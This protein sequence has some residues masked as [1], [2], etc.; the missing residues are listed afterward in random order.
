[1]DLVGASHRHVVARTTTHQRHIHPGDVIRPAHHLHLVAPQPIGQQHEHRVAAPPH[2]PQAGRRLAG[3]LPQAAAC[4]IPPAG[5]HGDPVPP[6]GPQHQPAHAGVAG[7]QLA[8][9]GAADQQGG[10][11]ALADLGGQSLEGMAGGAKQKHQLWRTPLQHGRQG[12]LHRR[13]RIP[14]GGVPHGH[15]AGSVVAAGG[16]GIGGEVGHGPGPLQQSPPNIDE[17]VC[18]CVFKVSL[19]LTL[20]GGPARSGGPCT[21][22]A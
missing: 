2:L 12:L 13:R 15:P 1:M 20:V 6:Q 22:P 3:R 21:I 7:R 4:R 5:G 8:G 19:G 9:G 14:L 11:D 17:D 10:A 16:W 18:G